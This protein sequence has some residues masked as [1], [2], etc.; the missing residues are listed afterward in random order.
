M[1]GDKLE[2]LFGPEMVYEPAG[3]ILRCV[4]CGGDAAHELQTITMHLRTSEGALHVVQSSPKE[5]NRILVCAEHKDEDLEEYIAGGCHVA[6][7]QQTGVASDLED[8]TLY[9]Q[10]L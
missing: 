8:Y 4:R 10:D 1:T 2:D 5:G 7:M 9:W 6:V 3:L